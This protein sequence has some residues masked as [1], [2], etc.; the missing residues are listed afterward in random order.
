M[1]PG[2]ANQIR[3]EP[4]SPELRPRAPVW[5]VAGSIPTIE[6]EAGI[7]LDLRTKRD[8]H[9]RRVARQRGRTMARLALLLLGDALAAT[10]AVLFGRSFIAQAN[11]Q[12]L[13][14]DLTLFIVITILGQ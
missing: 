8:L 13:S 12:P 7:P 10:A 9:S 14:S 1:T 2:T 5:R 4:A 3:V 6:W 11:P